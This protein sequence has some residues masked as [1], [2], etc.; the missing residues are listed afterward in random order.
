M[1]FGAI[2]CVYDDH[3]YLDISLDS[4][5]DNLD[6][7]LFLMSDIP[8][9]GEKSDNS[10]TIEKIKILCEKNKKFE[11]ITGHWSNEIDQRNFG[12]EY[13]IK[14]NIDYSF[15]I[16]SDEV[17]KENHFNNIL[18]FIDDHRQYDAFHLEWNTYWTKNYYKIY[19]REN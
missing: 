13:S 6:S 3:Q 4:V 1:K 14:N 8:W 12:L 10:E 15:I 9:N 11:L 7:V 18:R 16:D 17:Y 19:P 2:Y 5:K